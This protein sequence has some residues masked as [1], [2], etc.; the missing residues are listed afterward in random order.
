MSIGAQLGI[1]QKI[2]V[3]I[4]RKQ[5]F[6]FFLEPFV[7]KFHYNFNLYQ[8]MFSLGKNNN[9]NTFFGGKYNQN[10]SQNSLKNEVPLCDPYYIDIAKI[11][12]LNYK[13]F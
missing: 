2:E 9:N 4:R 8:I 11:K 5:Y 12:L 1:V 7:E 6:V 13:D 3:N 10:P